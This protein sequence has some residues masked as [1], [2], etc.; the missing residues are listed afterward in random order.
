MNA[1]KII[2]GILLF[3][4]M[5][6]VAQMLFKWGSDTPGRWAWGFF[7]GHAFGVSSIVILML[8]Y[9]TMHPNVALGLCLGGAFLMAQVALALV[10]RSDLSLA[11]Y[12]GI[13]AITAG[14]ILLAI[15]KLAIPG[16]R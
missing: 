12:L 3:W 15:G 13:V 5:Q 8:L 16:S 10:Y 7:I 11:Q 1:I 9:K 4:A 14:M 2:G 6:V